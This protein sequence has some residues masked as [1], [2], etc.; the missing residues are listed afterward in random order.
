MKNTFPGFVKK[1]KE[2]IQFLWENSTICF[3]AN[4]LLNLYRYSNNT[5][6]ALIDLI[7]NLIRKFGFHTKLLL[8]TIKID[9][10]L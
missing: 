4:V 1:T 3:D 8:N 9:M 7:K 5:K 10:R 6:D 2:E